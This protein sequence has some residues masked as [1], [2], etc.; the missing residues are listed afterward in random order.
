MTGT[1]DMNIIDRWEKSFANQ[2]IHNIS[3]TSRKSKRG[4]E[5]FFG[6]PTSVID[7]LFNEVYL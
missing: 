2:I 3:S 5:Y 4:A 6:H 7:D 1:I